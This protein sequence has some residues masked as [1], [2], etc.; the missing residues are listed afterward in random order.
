MPE[1]L[2]PEQ[3]PDQ[4]AEIEP[5]LRFG[6]TIA[7]IRLLV[8]RGYPQLQSLKQVKEEIQF[9]LSWRQ[10]LSRLTPEQQDA[11]LDSLLVVTQLIETVEKSR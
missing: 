1:Y 6:E 7:A 5:D 11:L 4:S 10:E 9:E 8:D 3:R 2:S